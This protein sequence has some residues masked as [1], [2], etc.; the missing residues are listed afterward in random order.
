MLFTMNIFRRSIKRWEYWIM[1]PKNFIHFCTINIFLYFWILSGTFGTPFTVVVMLSIHSWSM[2]SILTNSGVSFPVKV[3]IGVHSFICLKAVIE[4]IISFVDSGHFSMSSATIAEGPSILSFEF[5]IPL[6]VLGTNAAVP[7][8]R[9]T[10]VGWGP[11]CCTAV[12]Y[13]IPILFCCGFKG[14]LYPTIV[15]VIFTKH[16]N[17]FLT[18]LAIHDFNFLNLQS[19]F[20]LP[21]KYNR[22]K[23]PR[24]IPTPPLL[25]EDN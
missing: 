24:Y 18:I 25:L 21:S 9:L 7:S 11:K 10:W 15:L 16:E 22:T 6:D 1:I 8:I 14:R 2:T 17:I 13:L 5:P 19:M 23:R 4:A 20:G 3:D 12:D